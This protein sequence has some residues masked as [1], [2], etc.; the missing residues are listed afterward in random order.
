METTKMMLQTFI[1]YPINNKLNI[2]K[3]SNKPE[4]D[5]FKDQNIRSNTVNNTPLQ[6][7][8]LLVL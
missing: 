6:A 7:Y 3:P 1:L 4:I 2:E 8:V 5:A